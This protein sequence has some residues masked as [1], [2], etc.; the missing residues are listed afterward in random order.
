LEKS[1]EQ[2]TP[3]NAASSDAA[4]LSSPSNQA[5]PPNPANPT[6]NLHTKQRGELAEL[7]FM[8]KA[9]SMGFGVAKPWG[10]SERYDIILNAGRVLWRVQI[11]SI[12]S[13]RHCEVNATGS[14]RIP[15]TA[16]EIDFLVV[17]IKPRDPWYIFPIT[18]V[19]R[20]NIRLAPDLPTSRHEKYREAWKL[21]GEPS[22]VMPPAAIV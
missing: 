22:R 9:V 13:R 5:N 18:A 8:F 11:K 2:E 10:D 17:Y 15:Y 4:N 1:Q 14:N 20:P 6:A 12:F 21:F 19:L 16:D 3:V 7:A